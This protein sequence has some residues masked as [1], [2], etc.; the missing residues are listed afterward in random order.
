MTSSLDEQR[1]AFAAIRTA[2]LRAESPVTS[3]KV[4]P[5]IAAGR[6]IAPQDH[7]MLQ[8]AV[9]I[10][11]HNETEI[12][13]RPKKR[14]REETPE[15]IFLTPPASTI[16]YNLNV[17]K[18]EI[19]QVYLQNGAPD[20]L[21]NKN[22]GY[23]HRLTKE[24]LSGRLHYSPSHSI[25]QGSVVSDDT[26][27]LLKKDFLEDHYSFIDKLLVTP[28]M[29][30]IEPEEPEEEVVPMEV[31]EEEE[32]L[33]LVP[34]MVVPGKTMVPNLGL[35][36][37]HNGYSEAMAEEE[38][39][40]N[41]MW[42]WM[43]KRE[44]LNKK[45]IDDTGN[46]AE[47]WWIIVYNFIRSEPSILEKQEKLHNEA[48]EAQMRLLNGM[49]PNVSLSEVKQKLLVPFK[50]MVTTHFL[51]MLQLSLFAENPWPKRTRLGADIK[52]QIATQTKLS[53]SAVYERVQEM[54]LLILGNELQRPSHTYA[55]MAIRTRRWSFRGQAPNVVFEDPQNYPLLLCLDQDTVKYVVTRLISI[56]FGAIGNSKLRTLG[57]TTLHPEPPQMHSP[58]EKIEEPKYQLNSD[59]LKELVR[60]IQLKLLQGNNIPPDEMLKRF[61][62]PD[63]VDTAQTATVARM[64]IYPCSLWNFANN[65]YLNALFN[66][67]FLHNAMHDPIMY[68]VP[69]PRADSP[70]QFLLKVKLAMQVQKRLRY[71]AKYLR[72]PRKSTTKSVSENE[73]TMLQ[74]AQDIRAFAQ[75]FC[76]TQ[77]MLSDHDADPFDLYE[78]MMN[79]MGLG[80]QLGF[81]LIRWSWQP[82]EQGL[83]SEIS[84]QLPPSVIHM[85]FLNVRVPVNEE[86][87]IEQLIRNELGSEVESRYTGKL[88]LQAPY[89]LTIKL[90]RQTSVDE[91][92]PTI[93]QQ[94]FEVMDLSH[95]MYGSRKNTDYSEHD[96]AMAATP[97]NRAI[98]SLRAAVV[99]VPERR[100]YI[101]YTLWNQ[102]SRHIAGNVKTWIQVDSHP[103]KA[104][105][106][107][108]AAEAT[109]LGYPPFM[110]FVEPYG[111]PVL[112]QELPL[113]VRQNCHMLFY[114]RIDLSKH[115]FHTTVWRNFTT[116]MQDKINRMEMSPEQ[117]RRWKEEKSKSAAISIPKQIQRESMGS[118]PLNIPK[119]YTIIS[120]R[121]GEMPK[122]PVAREDGPTGWVQK[123]FVDK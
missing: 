91:S 62:Q 19:D 47:L 29:Q 21:Q 92:I 94:G 87:S 109:G 12:G 61:L 100:H 115:T 66:C 34:Q 35:L 42:Q 50:N 56:I 58:T 22:D 40:S 11:N 112:K 119:F 70:E 84:Q 60:M 44:L 43:I 74:Y 80:H 93:A 65:C 41:R 49:M 13:L 83:L 88:F 28:E 105:G 82:D 16:V 38:H 30:E 67:L 7:M 57:V 123:E 101:C 113:S 85:P 25:Q 103:D 73:T 81:D 48:R 52:N 102:M 106:S 20:L 23:L 15:K 17:E 9:N 54:C 75:Y 95:L 114:E 39:L 72:A 96:E 104:Y 107:R 24:D 90:N 8:K 45:T 78:C 86:L 64:P 31:V 122:P 69:L 33:E 63:N 71:I 59:Q 37:R 120:G 3:L 110:R 76:P 118:V 32:L 98:Y 5:H 4:V 10:A 51:M 116:K 117:Y 68:S 108:G 89:S 121:G 79:T 97:I 111:M 99:Y 27:E 36:F 2:A 26:I 18:V 46:S 1:M 6:G 77:R 14:P 53:E 55:T